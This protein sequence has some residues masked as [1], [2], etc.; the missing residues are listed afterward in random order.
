MI[1][2]DAAGIYDM[3]VNRCL[4][5]VTV[6]GDIDLLEQLLAVVPPRAFEAV[7]V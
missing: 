5:Q 2:G 6:T 7:S 1:E 4:D 3:F